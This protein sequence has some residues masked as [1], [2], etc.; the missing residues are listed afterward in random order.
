M[1]AALPELAQTLPDTAAGTLTNLAVEYQRLFGFNLPPYES[2]FVDPSS[3]LMAP[4]TE[5]IQSLYQQGGWQLP[6]NVRSGGPD[7]LGAELLAL[8]DWQDS[9]RL[10]LAHRLHARH[11][12]LWAPVFVIT[13]W[14]LAPHPF[15]QTL[16]QLTL[17]LLLTTLPEDTIPQTEDLFPVLPPPPIYRDTEPESFGHQNNLDSPEI[18]PPAMDESTTKD[19]QAENSLR[20]VVKHLLTTRQTGLYLT[21]EDMAQIGD[22]L[23]LPGVMGER[24]RMLDGLFRQA[25]QYDLIPDLVEHLEQLVKDTRAAYRRLAN[26]YPHWVPYAKAWEGR[27]ENTGNMLNDMKAASTQP[28][29]NPG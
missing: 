20:K 10:D 1:I 11:L 14:R 23:D 21:R 28:D 15:Y 24:H 13:L 18:I 4:S 16:S 25:G 29:I 17:E 8:A 22:A 9:A 26:E 12:A 6:Q 19:S 2:V 7:H 3:M 27:L 5:R